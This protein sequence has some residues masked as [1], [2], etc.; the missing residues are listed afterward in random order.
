LRIVQDCLYIASIE[1]LFSQ[2]WGLHEDGTVSR[3]FEE[4]KAVSK[5]CF[6]R[7]SEYS[8]KRSSLAARGGSAVQADL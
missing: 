1:F 2:D 4:A 3:N 7:G 5:D 6:G 8:F